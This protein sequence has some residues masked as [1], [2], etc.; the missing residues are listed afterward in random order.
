MTAPE[1]GPSP[2]ERALFFAALVACLAA[3]VSFG[4]SVRFE[5]TPWTMYVPIAVVGL[6]FM[7]GFVATRGRPGAEAR[8]AIYRSARRS[9]AVLIGVELVAA[10]GLAAAGVDAFGPIGM[11]GLAAS[12]VIAAAATASVLASTSTS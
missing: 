3:L 4:V 8:V 12:A 1:G 6:I 5:E 2:E 7:F 10:F 11:I 9:A